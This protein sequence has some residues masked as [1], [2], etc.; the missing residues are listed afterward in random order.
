MPMQCCGADTE[1]VGADAYT[2]AYQRITATCFARMGTVSELC[3]VRPML[4][5]V[6]GSR[7]GRVADE[8][9]ANYWARRTLNLTLILLWL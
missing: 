4:R 1:G 7:V 9:N 3:R 8:A 5:S 6:Q 2:D